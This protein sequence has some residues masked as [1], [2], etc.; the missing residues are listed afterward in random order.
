M[1]HLLIEHHYAGCSSGYET[2][3]DTKNVIGAYSTAELAEMNKPEDISWEDEYDRGGTSY[4][5]EMVMLDEPFTPDN[6][7][8]QKGYMFDNGDE[9]GI[10]YIS[11]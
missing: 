4:S 9:D 11:K 1:L 5:I 2:Y 8:Q 10:V 3:Q 7:A 6:D